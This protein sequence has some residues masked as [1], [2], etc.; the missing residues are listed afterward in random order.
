MIGLIADDQEKQRIVD[1]GVWLE[2]RRVKMLPDFVNSFPYLQPSRHQASSY[3]KE[4][5]DS[6]PFTD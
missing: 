6:Y 3:W 2:R 1:L 4:Q 5:P